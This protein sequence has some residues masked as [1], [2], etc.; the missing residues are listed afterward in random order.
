MLIKHEVILSKL[1]IT[2]QSQKQFQVCLDIGQSHQLT[3]CITKLYHNHKV[4]QIH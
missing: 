3:T 1:I 2:F 4:T